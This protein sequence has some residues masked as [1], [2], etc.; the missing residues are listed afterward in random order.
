MVAL[1]DLGVLV[2]SVSSERSF[3]RAR[4]IINYHR[5]NIS[6]EHAKDQLI[7]KCNR[8]ISLDV[9]EQLNDFE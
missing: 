6:V 8:G 2:T 3:S 1:E 4:Y 5:T 9:F 7:I